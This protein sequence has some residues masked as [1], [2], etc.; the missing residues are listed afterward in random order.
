MIMKNYAA[1]HVA[2][3]MLVGLGA[4]NAL[5]AANML[6]GIADTARDFAGSV[7]RVV[8][9]TTTKHGKHPEQQSIANSSEAAAQPSPNF[10]TQAVEELAD[11]EIF[12][13]PSRRS[14]IFPKWS[15]FADFFKSSEEATTWGQEFG[16]DFFKGG[17]VL[18]YTAFTNNPEAIERIKQKLSEM[19]QE[20]ITTRTD[21]INEIGDRTDELRANAVQHMH[22]SLSQL[23]EEAIEDIDTR[24][25]QSASNVM[26]Q[27]NNRITSFT[28]NFLQ[29]IDSRIKQFHKKTG[30]DAA[31]MENIVSIDTLA[32]GFSLYSAKKGLD[33]A[34][35][36]NPKAIPFMAP[37]LAFLGY[38]IAQ[39]QKIKKEEEHELAM[40]AVTKRYQRRMQVK[41]HSH[42]DYIGYSFGCH[43]S[44]FQK[45]V[46]TP[47][48]KLLAFYNTPLTTP[49]IVQ[50]F[51]V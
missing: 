36:S 51:R 15:N 17:A 14:S 30:R 31:K 23:R 43:K 13:L 27:F 10:P 34:A 26:E 41:N 47:S 4:N 33:L 9:S 28:E 1:I 49:K 18:A 37:G 39:Q 16:Q 11:E 19:K 32:L 6:T 12:P 50:R 48:I 7:G 35:E 44:K 21:T 20:A 40:A 45:P 38:K 8:R 24:L 25:N 3:G 22:Q 46:D 5:T 2:L 42:A 29:M